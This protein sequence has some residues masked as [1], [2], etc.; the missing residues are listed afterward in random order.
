V[1]TQIAFTMPA[2]RAS[3]PKP[4]FQGMVFA[5]EGDYAVESWNDSKVEGWITCRQGQFR[6]DMDDTVTHLI[7]S[8]DAYMPKKGKQGPRGKS[9]LQVC[10]EDE[11]GLVTR[12]PMGRLRVSRP[13]NC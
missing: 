9:L 6:H 12:P 5:R 8:H 4:I 10:P 13:L 2:R 7:C 11:G 1:L 3:K